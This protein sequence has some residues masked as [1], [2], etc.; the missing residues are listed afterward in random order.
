[1]V[2]VFSQIFLLR[3]VLEIIEFFDV[4]ARG[5][6]PKLAH[7]LFLVFLVAQEYGVDTLSDTLFACGVSLLLNA[8][9]AAYTANVEFDGI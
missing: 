4:V 9:V 8:H 3:R 7:P 5:G 2:F 6:F 1:L